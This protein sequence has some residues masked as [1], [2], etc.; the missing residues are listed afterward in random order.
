MDLSG[1]FTAIATPFKDGKLDEDGLRRNVQF[2]IDQGIDGLLPVGTTGESPTLSREEHEK[3]IDITI[4][5]AKG[6]VKVIAGACSNSTQ[7]S[8]QYA[9]HARE[10]GADAA[11][12]IVPYYNKPTQEGL[13]QHFKAIA[14]AVDIPQVVYN[15]PSRTVRNIDA[16]T[17]LRLTKFDNIVAIKEA[18]CDMDQI[19]NILKGAPDDFKV[20]SGEDSWTYAMMAMGGHGVISVAS[21]LAPKMVTDMVHHALDGNFAEARDLHYKLFDFFKVIF[22][23][24]NPSPVKYGLELMGMPSGKTRLPLVEPRDA[25]KAKIKEVMQDLELI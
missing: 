23:E 13:Y 1:A 24:T 2:Q 8:I 4:E 15:V 11:L 19:A 7:E 12:V 5:E 17:M 25:S 3:V 10:M 21:N 9:E 20:L 18:G 14:E 6:K 22:I 16:N